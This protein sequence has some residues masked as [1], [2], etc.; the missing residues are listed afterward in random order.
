MNWSLDQ[1][2][3]FVCSVEAGSFSA[4]ARKLGKAQSRVSSAIANLELD[5][6]VTL[7]DRSAKLPVL[8]QD[9]KQIYSEAIAVLAQCQRLEARAMSVTKE[10]EISLTIAMDEAVLIDPF[11]LM[12][13]QLAEVYPLLKLTI[14][15]GTRSDISAWVEQ[16]KAD[17]G[18]IF[19]ADDLS[20]QL[21]YYS[22]DR[23]YQTLIVSEKHP[24]AKSKRPSLTELVNHRQLVIC[25]LQGKASK[26]ISPNYWMLDSYY[27]ITGMVTRGIG[28]ALVPEHV[29]RSDWYIEHGLVELDT[30]HIPESL[31]IEVGVVKRRDK[32]VGE[33]LEWLFAELETMF[34]QTRR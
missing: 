13:M 12:F 16:G 8:T 3:A 26:P 14:I 19:S 32:G 21:E 33:V 22:V 18:I 24:L 28:W 27:Y 23:F 4:A 30:Y 15:N 9:G 11:E 10:V 25:D 31:L 6:G 1:L 2:Q 34:K 29:A 17:I 20:E 5:L 7:F